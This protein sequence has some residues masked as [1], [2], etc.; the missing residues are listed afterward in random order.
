MRLDNHLLGGA[1]LGHRL[2]RIVSGLLLLVPLLLLPLLASADPSLGYPNKAIKIIVPFPAGGTADVLPRIIGQKLS[3][4]FGQPVIIENRA[5]AGG[6]IGAEAVDKSAPDGYTLLATPP[7]PLA[8]NQSLFRTLP[9][10]PERFMPITVLAAVPNVLAV[11]S[12]MQATSTASFIALAKKAPGGFNVATQGNG[13]TSHLTA[14]MFSAQ[15]G[16]QFV[17][18][19][20]KGTT[21]ALADLMGGQV[22]VF[23]DNIGSMHKHHETGKTKILAVASSK[24]SALLPDIPTIAESGLPGFNSSTWFAMAAP[25]G[26]PP[27]IVQKLHAA[28]I[29]VLK[30]KDVQ[31]KFT[32]L[33]A[34]IVGNSPK[35]MQGF[36]ISE[37]QRW[38]KVIDNAG[39]TLN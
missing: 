4:K 32:A 11:R 3:E 10:D 33:G 19:P 37:R 36:L 8:I 23:F 31:E 7:A 16:I 38:K 25:A 24:R 26:T 13:T 35:E 12:N 29:E 30:M 1:P 2:A 6:N 34:D 28:I 27:E 5:G 9:F 22:D 14:S 17:Y 18:I 15:A 39:V 21:P 20:Y